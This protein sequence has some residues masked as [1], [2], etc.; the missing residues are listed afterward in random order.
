MSGRRLL[1]ALILS[2]EL[3]AI[4]CGPALACSIKAQDPEVFSSS[5]PAQTQGWTAGQL[6]D[7]AFKAAGERVK[8][9]GARVRITTDGCTIH[10]DVR[11]DAL[12]AGAHFSVSFSA[13]DLSV[14]EVVGGE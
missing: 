7:A 14:L 4:I 11:L 6:A 1:N 9:E 5:C 10:V 13:V 8:R 12:H 2:A 3:T